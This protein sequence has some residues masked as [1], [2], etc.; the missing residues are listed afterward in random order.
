VE[1]VSWYGELESVRISRGTGIHG[2]VGKDNTYD[3]ERYG[4]R[5]DF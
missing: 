5:C 4:G 2:Y 3:S 1:G